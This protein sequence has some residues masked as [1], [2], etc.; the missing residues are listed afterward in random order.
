MKCY[1]FISLR[2]VRSTDDDDDRFCRWCRWRYS[3][4]VNGPVVRVR[5][6]WDIIKSTQHKTH[7]IQL[8]PHY[9][10]IHPFT[11]LTHSLTAFPLFDFTAFNVLNW[12]KHVECLQRKNF[13]IFIRYF[14]EQIYNEMSERAS[15]R[16]RGRQREREW[17]K[18][19]KGGAM[20]QIW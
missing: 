6:T 14:D 3:M 16:T 1:T 13:I 11:S 9:P 20:H 2:C 17:A 18:W 15:T 12:N 5:L 10:E 4:A 7:T 19:E 8:A